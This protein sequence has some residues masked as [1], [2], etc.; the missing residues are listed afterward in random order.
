MTLPTKY[1]RSLE[2][3]RI[4]Q[5]AVRHAELVLNIM[6]MT[7]RPSIQINVMALLN[8]LCCRFMMFQI[9]AGAQ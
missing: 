3:A 8:A 2:S 5:A 7:C 4:Q 1:K 6:K 9:L